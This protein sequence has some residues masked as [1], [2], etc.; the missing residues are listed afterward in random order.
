MI[1]PPKK[2][3]RIQPGEKYEFQMRDKDGH[4]GVWIPL[5]VKLAR[6]MQKGDPESKRFRLRQIGIS[7]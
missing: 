7:K 4:W 3:I 6:V 2:F 5:G 1:E